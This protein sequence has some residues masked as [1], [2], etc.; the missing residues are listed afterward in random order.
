MKLTE[1]QV[2]YVAT[3]ANLNLTSDELSRMQHDLEEILT[4]VDKL[5][6]LDTTG[7][8]PMAQVLVEDDETS[9]LRRDVEQPSLGQ[10][11][12]LANAP[13]KGAGHFKVPRVIE[14]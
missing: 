11:I 5:A 12:A 4:H 13:A 3:L 9:A 2:S 10:D 6:E 14:R 1:N 8:E 7:I